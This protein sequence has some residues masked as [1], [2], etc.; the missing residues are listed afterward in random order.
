MR[1]I[2]TGRTTGSSSPGYSWGLRL[3]GTVSAVKPGEADPAFAE[4]ATRD[5]VTAYHRRMT[6]LVL[7]TIE[8]IPRVLLL[9]V[10]VLGLI[11][12][13]KGRARGVS[14]LLVAAFA[15]V[16][17][18]TVAGIAWQFVSLN[19]PSWIRAN[20]LSASDINVIFLAVGVPLDGA[21][22]LSWLLVAIGVVKSGRARA[23]FTPYPGPV[24]Y[25][26]QPPN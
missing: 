25:Y 10:G 8:V 18:T 2:R 20:H 22:V 12:S 4:S 7:T 9:V 15:V 23:A 11:F 1:P 19:A 26:Q 14:G 24:N 16:L 3:G 6:P 5:G 17:V 21:A 13:I